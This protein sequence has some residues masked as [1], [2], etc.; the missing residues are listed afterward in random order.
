MKLENNSSYSEGK[1]WWCYTVRCT[2]YN[3][4]KPLKNDSFFQGFRSDS[5]LSL[6]AVIKMAGRQ[7]QYYIC[8]TLGITQPTFT[9]LAKKFTIRMQINNNQMKKPDR[10]GTLA[11]TYGTMMN[12]ACESHQCRSAT[13][14][15]DAICI[16]KVAGNITKVWAQVIPDKKSSTML[17]IIHARSMN[18]AIIHTD[19]H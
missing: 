4:R 17:P 13:N 9:K 5:R 16:V 7:Y 15:T 6:I 14:R 3:L 19:E 10:P 8:T 1:C 2:R 11:Q 18:G 12:Y